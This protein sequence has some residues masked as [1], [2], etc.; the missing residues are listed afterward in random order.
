MGANSRTYKFALA[1]ALLDLAKQGREVVPLPILAEK[2]CWSL[3]TRE[4]G[5]PPGPR[6]SPISP[7]QLA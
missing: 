3:L 2:Y 5:Y 4:G 7:R 6:Q 1:A